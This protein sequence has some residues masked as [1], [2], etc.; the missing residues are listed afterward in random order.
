MHNTLNQNTESLINNYGK[1]TKKENEDQR[2]SLVNQLR[3][4]LQDFKKNLDEMK[5]EKESQLS[6]KKKEDSK[7]TIT[8][9]IVKKENDKITMK[10]RIF[11]SKEKM[12]KIREKF[13]IAKLRILKKTEDDFND[14]RKCIEDGEINLVT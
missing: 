1:T 13:I 6:I 3:S 14:L 11:W 10:D 4:Q 5:Q 9:F 7:E 2:L 12:Q 8:E